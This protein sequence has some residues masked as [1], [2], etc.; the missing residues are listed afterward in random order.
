MYR[1]IL[2]TLLLLSLGISI[3]AI[4]FFGLGVAGVLF[5]QELISGRTL[6]GAI[7]ARVL[8]RLMVLLSASAVI[9]AGCA[10][11]LFTLKKRSLSIVTLISVS[12]LLAGALYLSLV[13]FPEADEMRRAIGSFDPVIPTKS[14]IYSEFQTA[15]SRFSL[16]SRGLFLLAAG[17]FVSHLLSLTSKVR[18]D[19]PTAAESVVE[20]EVQEG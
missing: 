15:H 11:P 19:A 17:A 6:S 4:L 3:G 16:M 12:L 1:R 18:F 5:D 2:H 14:A 8:Q 9:S 7:N 20:A 13:L 10:V